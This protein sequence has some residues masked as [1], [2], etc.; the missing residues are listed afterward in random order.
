MKCGKVNDKYVKINENWK[1]L[2]S[3]IIARAVKD[4]KGTYRPKEAKAFLKSD[5][6]ET[7]KFFVSLKLKGSDSFADY[8][9]FDNYN[10]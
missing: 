8:S 5:W 3:A 4:S 6:C 9:M 10:K 2:A 1:Y 7:L